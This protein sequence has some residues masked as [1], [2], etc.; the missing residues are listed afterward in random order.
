MLKKKRK[1]YSLQNG[2]DG[3]AYGGLMKSG[4]RYLNVPGHLSQGCQWNVHRGLVI[5]KCPVQSNSSKEEHV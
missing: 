2:P 3:R 4:T 5:D 1:G